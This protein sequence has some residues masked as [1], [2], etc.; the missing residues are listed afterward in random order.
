MMLLTLFLAFFQIGLFSIGGGYAAMPLIEAQ[1]VDKYAWL[2]L[3]EFADVITIAEMTPGP[4]ALNAASFVGIRCCGII[5]AIIATFGCILPSSIIVLS[6]AALYMK[7]RNMDMLKGILSLLRVAV[8]SM[9]LSA[10]LSIL[11]MAL[12]N[13]SGTGFDALAVT[14][15]IIAFILI[16][17]LKLSPIKTI[18]ISGL[19]YTV[20]SVL[21]S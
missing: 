12:Y 19:L 21:L 7:Y 16:R 18:F 10:T 20:V 3:E 8:V 4:I 1:V 2:T 13:E 17:Y 6:L 11:S 14:V 9:I 15:F 5:G